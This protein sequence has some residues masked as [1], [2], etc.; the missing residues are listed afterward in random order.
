MAN[1]ICIHGFAFALLATPLGAVSTL[2][3]SFQV[4]DVVGRE[5][6]IE[7]PVTK[8]ILGEGRLLYAVAAL[9]RENP[10]ARV[11]GWRDDLIKNDPQT[12]AF[13][14][15]RFP[16]ADKLPTFGGVKDGTFDAE[17]AISLDPDVVIMNLEAQVATE[18]AGLDDKLAA[19]GIPI[20]YVDFRDAPMKN[21]EPSL[22]LLGVLF[23]AKDCAEDLASYRREVIVTIT[24]RL[25]EA[26]PER[27]LVFVERAAGYSDECCMSFGNES[28]GMLVDMAGGHNMASEFLPGT[29]GTVNPEQVVASNPAQVVVT[30]ANWESS[31]PGGG[32]VGLGP[33]ADMDE[34]RNKL[35]A[36]M[37]RPAYV[38][39][40]AVDQQNVHG[41][42][43]QF[44]NS[45]YHF[46]A[47]QQMAKWFHP[48]L[49]ADQDPEATF[50][51]LHER[52]LP[53]PYAPG[54]FVSLKSED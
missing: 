45:P 33:D 43:H 17:Q 42:W 12:Y 36:L 35:T 52:F 9:E 53:V 3:E 32:W 48:D 44:Y 13:Y 41:V 28:F 24:D 10:F 7:G 27:P 16:Q 54:Y 14:R 20:V 15:E 49:F 5:V 22:E 23:D 1:N 2:A 31:A 37:E 18:D 51:E 47:L 4:T 25:K 6:A 38:G 46:I 34:A 39:V 8:V 26:N 40:A 19:V 50:R 29:F 21:T 30:G 11:V